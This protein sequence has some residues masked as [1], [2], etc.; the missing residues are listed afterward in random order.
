MIINHT[1]KTGEWKKLGRGTSRQLKAGE[2]DIEWEVE[3]MLLFS[4]EKTEGLSSTIK[5]NLL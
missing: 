1:F 4:L 2:H 5:C 3:R